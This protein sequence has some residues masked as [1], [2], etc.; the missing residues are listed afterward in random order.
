MPTSRTAKKRVRQN[1]KR[2]VRHKGRRSE[3]KT[4]AKSKPA[5]HGLDVVDV[6][7]PLEVECVGGNRLPVGSGEPGSAQF[8]EV[9][10]GGTAAWLSSRLVS[11]AR[12]RRS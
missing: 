10:L 5:E 12:I 7:Q 9:K 8:A 1:D 11:H 2:R 3:I 4:I 6:A